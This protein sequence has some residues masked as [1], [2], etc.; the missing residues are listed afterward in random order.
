MD[1]NCGYSGWS[2]SKRASEAY[3]AG[4]MPKSKWTKSKMVEALEEAAD[5]SGV[6]IPDKLFTLSKETL[7]T[8][9][10]THASWHHTSL[11]CNATDFYGVDE[12]ALSCLDAGQVEE[13]LEQERLSRAAAPRCSARQS[14]SDANYAKVEFTEWIG[15]GS[16]KNPVR[17][18]G[19]GTIDGR[20]CHLIEPS[21]SGASRKS[22]DSA[23]CDV[24]A[25][26]G[27]K[28]EM[29][30]D[31]AATRVGEFS[32]RCVEFEVGGAVARAFVRGTWLHVVAE[33]GSTCRKK[34]CSSNEI[35][36]IK[37]LL[38][39][40]LRKEK[41]PQSAALLELR[42]AFNARCC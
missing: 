30:D 13:W 29:L 14:A 7:F 19:W 23:H 27:S 26:F 1:M 42:D 22:I 41:S 2:M 9:L 5:C 11:L 35:G 8:K 17:Q 3:S 12:E 18:F 38:V 39:G 40:D 28:K 36:A 32:G 6:S 10:F 4:E 15:R 25:R 37:P 24:K 21:A 34:A 33:D 16:H 31:R 20:W